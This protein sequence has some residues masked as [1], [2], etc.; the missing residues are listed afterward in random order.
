MRRHSVPHRAMRRHVCKVVIIAIAAGG[1]G[2]QGRDPARSLAE[3]IAAMREEAAR[4]LGAAERAGSVDSI[5]SETEAYAGVVQSS[6]SGMRGDLAALPECRSEGLSLAASAIDALELELAQ[7]RGAIESVR[8]SQE[9]SVDPG[10][11]VT[12]ALE[13]TR[14]H[15][16][17]VSQNLDDLALAV[18]QLGCEADGGSVE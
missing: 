11:Y 6:I 8:A 13:E 3:R 2:T 15:A 12:Q 7:H 5:W 1:C 9:P 10:A 18:G 16:L 17:R 14:A 4:H